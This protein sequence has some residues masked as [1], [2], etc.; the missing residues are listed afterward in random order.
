MLLNFAYPLCIFI[1]VN[2]K[3][4]SIPTK[5]QFILIFRLNR[6]KLEFF[7]KCAFGK[8]TLRL[9]FFTIFCMHV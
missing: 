7:S 4:C 9:N 3:F 8:V 5:S 1:E 6:A 2:V